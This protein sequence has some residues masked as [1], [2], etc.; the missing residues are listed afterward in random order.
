[1]EAPPPHLR[2]AAIVSG[3][4]W[5]PFQ[6]LGKLKAQDYVSTPVAWLLLVGW[7]AVEV[8]T[9]MWAGLRHDG[10]SLKVLWIGEFI[11]PHEHLRLSAGAEF[12]LLL[13]FKVCCDLA[14][15]LISHRLAVHRLNA[16]EGGLGR[17]F[18]CYCV[19]MGVLD[20]YFVFTAL[21]AL[22]PGDAQTAMSASHAA[23]AMC[24]A[25]NIAVF[26]RAYGQVYGLSDDRAFRGFFLGIIVIPASLLLIFA[27]SGVIASLDRAFWHLLT[28]P[29]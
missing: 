7:S 13:V 4:L 1:M 10:N 29:D 3:L 12:L 24:L 2:P 6:T 23:L 17:W 21:I 19:L 8:L 28:P 20:I 9:W 27:A 26:T 5:R 18:R 22:L 16:K 15:I 25:W 11:S 14:L